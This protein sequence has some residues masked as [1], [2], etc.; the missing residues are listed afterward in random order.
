MQCRS[1]SFESQDISFEMRRL[2]KAFLEFGPKIAL[3]AGNG[4]EL[5]AG[6]RFK[7]GRA[8][9]VVRLYWSHAIHRC[10]HGRRAR[11]RGTV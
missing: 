1:L 6:E 9:S 11:K 3:K 4:T 10:G 7:R 8:P 5:S 2:A